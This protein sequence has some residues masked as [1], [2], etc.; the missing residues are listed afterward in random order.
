LLLMPTL[1]IVAT[2]LPGKD[3]SIAEIVGRGFEMTGNTAPFDVTG[4][5]AMTVPCGLVSG[6]P[7]GLMLVGNDYCE[8]TIYK[9][10][11]AYEADCDWKTL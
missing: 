10:A 1:P 11:A 8:A 2:P 9:A 7:V 4:H 6:L 3:A 5:P